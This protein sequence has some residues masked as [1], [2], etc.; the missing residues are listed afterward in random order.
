MK[1]PG[2]GKAK[3]VG[4]A[5]A[6]VLAAA[7]LLGCSDDPNGPSDAQVDPL[8]GYWGTVYSR[9]GGSPEYRGDGTDIYWVIYSTSTVCLIEKLPSGEYEKDSTFIYEAKDGIFTAR[10]DL[11]PVPLPQP[12]LPMTYRFSSRRDTLYFSWQALEEWP[13]GEMT[14]VR[15]ETVPN[16]GC[17][18]IP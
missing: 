17:D 12:A 16:C 13:E 7:T 2:Q 14:L 15:K 4:I 6:C 3:I 9:F 5:I 8:V 18:A 10:F 1:Q 11:D